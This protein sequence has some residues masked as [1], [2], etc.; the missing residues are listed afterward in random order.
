[1]RIGSVVVNENEFADVSTSDELFEKIDEWLATARIKNVDIL[2]LPAFIGSLLEID[3]VDEV[4]KISKK[5]E[6]IYLCPGSYIEKADEESFHSSFVVKNGEIILWQRQLYLSKWERELGL[7]RGDKI[8]HIEIGDLKVGIIISTDTFYPQVSRY[9]AM[10]RVDIVLSPVAI[11][12]EMNTYKQLSG[13]W[14]NVQQN[15][16]FAA[17]SGFKGDF[18]KR[19]FNS[20]SIIHGPLEM[21]DNLDGILAKEKNESIIMVELDNQRRK[22]AIDVFNPLKYLNNEFYKEYLFKQGG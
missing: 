6:E 18:Q 2:L 5:Y 1:M 8:E 12:G 20:N 3:Y 22:K 15:L 19:N 11:I 13:L 7:S 14:Q 9:M 10:S 17:E 4:I 21:T 16:F